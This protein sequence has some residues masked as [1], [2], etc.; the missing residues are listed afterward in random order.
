MPLLPE[1]KNQS[2]N[3][4]EMIAS[5]GKTHKIGTSHPKDKKAAIRQ[6]IA[7]SYKKAGEK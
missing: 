1:K 3:I 5:Y 4:S 6:A 2:R 7:I